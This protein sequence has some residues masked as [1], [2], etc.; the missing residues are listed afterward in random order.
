MAITDY[1]GT[2]TG[3]THLE[4]FTQSDH[5][6]ETILHRQ[7]LGQ[8]AYDTWHL[9][10]YFK[11]ILAYRNLLSLDSISFDLLPRKEKDLLLYLLLSCNSQAETVL[12]LGS[13]LFEMIDGLELVEKYAA[14]LNGGLPIVEIERLSFIGVE[15]SSLLS[16][17]SLVL[18]PEYQIT[19][20][21]NT[22]KVTGSFDVLYDRSVSNYAFESAGEVANFINRSKVALLNIYLSKG[23]I[24]TSARL[25]KLLTYFSLEEV[26][27]GLDKPLYHLFGEKAPGP[28]SGPELS[29]GKP[30]V[31]G[32]FLCCQQEFADEFIAVAQRVPEIRAYFG[33]KN[34]HL[35]KA[36]DYLAGAG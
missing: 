2:K 35:T 14:G 26:A 3:V 36:L 34:I 8:D 5:S 28:A 23:E 30:V 21:P 18:H 22:T 19:L 7:L 24:F 17:A 13:S 29:M 31:E 25:G 10:M 15:L 6:N 16:S 9:A 33:Y 27:E 20:Y 12:E 4:I 1:Y 11:E 32:F